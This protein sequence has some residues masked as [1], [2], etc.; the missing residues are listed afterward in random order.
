MLSV[1][2]IVLP[3]AKAPITVLD[4]TCQPHQTILLDIVASRTPDYLHFGLPCGTASRARD[5]PVAQSLQRMGAPNPPQLRSAQFPLGNPA[6]PADSINR[7]RLAKANA[8]YQF[9]LKLL[10]LVMGTPCV[11]SFENPARS[12]FWA[13]MTA[14]ILQWRK[15]S[16]TTFWNSLIDVEFDTCCHG[17]SRKKLTRW[18]STAG[19]FDKLR[20]FCAGDHEHEPYQ[21]RWNGSHWAFDTA[22]E[23]AY[24]S[25]LCRTIAE[26]LQ[27]HVTTL[28]KSLCHPQPIRHLTLAMQHRQHRRRKALISE[29][30]STRIQPLTQPCKISKCGFLQVKGE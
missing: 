20:K 25:T 8:L 6:I 7:I 16:L 30:S 26:L 3:E 15:P 13:A 24:P 12:W 2:H 27:S 11:V 5:K 18:K 23:A 14:L 29:Y 4:L 10:L 1:D 9:A 19:I 22:S 21:V 28:G 17:G